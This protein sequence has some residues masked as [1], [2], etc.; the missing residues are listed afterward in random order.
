M[1]KHMKIL[2]LSLTVLLMFGKEMPVQAE[3]PED[4]L[5]IITEVYE[6][7]LYDEDSAQSIYEESKGQTANGWE[8]LLPGGGGETE[9][10]DNEEEEAEALAAKVIAETIRETMVNRESYVSFEYTNKTGYD[11]ENLKRWF[12]MALAE[13][14]NSDEG[15]YLRWNY[16][17]YAAKI[18][19]Y[20]M[21][22]AYYFEYEMTFTYY[23]TASQEAELTKCIET[24]LGNLGVDNPD[25]SDYEKTKKIYDYI[26]ENITYDN[27]NLNDESYKMKFTAYAAMMH[28]TAVCQGY[29][30]LMY[31]MLEECDIDT[32]VIFGVSFG[33]NHA[34]NIVNLGSVYYLADSTWDAGKKN[35]S[36][37]LNSKDN[38]ANHDAQS[39]FLSEYELAEDDYSPVRITLDKNEL[40]LE[41]GVSERL[42]AVVVRENNKNYVPQWTS[43]DESI[44]TVDRNGNV[45]GRGDG[46]AII[47][48][49]VPGDKAICRVTVTHDH[50]GR[51]TI[52]A[53]DPTCTE[54]GCT[55]EI[56]CYLCDGVIVESEEIPPL[57]HSYVNRI[58]SVCGAEKPYSKI[59]F[60]SNIAYKEYT[61]KPVSV[62]AKHLDLSKA[63]KNFKAE[64]YLDKA[65]KTPTYKGNNK[66]VKTAPV[67]IGTYYVKIICPENEEYRYTQTKTPLKFVV[68]PRKAASLKAA[69]QKASI[70]LSWG[71]R[72]EATGYIIYRKTIDSDY[73]VIKTITKKTTNSYVD[74]NISKGMKYF[75]NI[76][77]YKTV[78]G[79][80]IKSAKRTGDTVIVRTKITNVTN[81]NGSVKIKWTRVSDAAGYKVYRKAA[82]KKSYTLLKNIKNGKETTYTDKKA[83]SNG[84]KYQY[85]VLPYYESA[86]KV[87]LKTNVQTN[88]Y[89]KQPVLSYVKKSGSTAIKIKWK[90]NRQASG[91]Q[92]RY[93]TTKNFKSSKSVTVASKNINYK[94][95]SG[96]KKGK[97]YYV[98]IRAYKKVNGKKYYSSWSAKKSA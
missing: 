28:K 40:I 87:T 26:C 65:C 60:K 15:D 53:T 21:D 54:P 75:Y 67:N 4:K 80:K 91:Y 52:W 72:N 84:K 2:L 3:E 98:Q 48:A 25:L 41:W 37:F 49:A 76:V 83:L 8:N 95:I 17:K 43:S 30:T 89:V 42:N 68:R 13:T 66:K 70:K 7:P 1:F 34:W 44:A 63:N 82:G 94:K 90:E 58:C 64:Y 57:G 38:F 50:M 93:S 85:Y 18:S 55:E 23:T 6:N 46:V 32:R 56:T 51:T 36:Y 11:A 69:N 31:R 96:L 62:E 27:E 47:K 97:K 10:P 20:S 35:Y 29:A 74:K 33:E 5:H 88:C 14:D 77:T 92:I 86:E 9:D 24:T 45:T 16:E 81:E 39:P 12:E 19:Y 61:G 59:V 73:E 79:Q 22:G 78:N 71:K